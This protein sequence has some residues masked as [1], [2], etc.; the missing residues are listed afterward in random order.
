MKNLKITAFQV[1]RQ[2]DGCGFVSFDYTYSWGDVISPGTCSNLLCKGNDEIRKVIEQ[3][4]NN[5]WPQ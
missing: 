5:E 4:M 3:L 2:D 1:N